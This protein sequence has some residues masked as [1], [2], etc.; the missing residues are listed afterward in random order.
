MNLHCKPIPLC[1]E[2]LSCYIFKSLT[3]LFIK[4]VLLLCLYAQ[5]E[6]GVLEVGD[7]HPHLTMSTGSP[8]EEGGVGEG[9]AAGTWLP[10]LT[11]KGISHVAGLQRATSLMKMDQAEQTGLHFPAW[12]LL[13]LSPEVFFLR[14]CLHTS[15][16]LSQ[17]K[18]FNSSSNWKGLTTARLRFP[19]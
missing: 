17:P 6:L 3:P 12:V 8:F 7:G 9:H 18:G 2:I 11:S 15:F 13:L 14:K 4:N 10:I 19:E 5:K 16:L 1:S